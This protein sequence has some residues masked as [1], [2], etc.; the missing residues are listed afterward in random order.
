MLSQLTIAKKDKNKP[1][2]LDREQLYELGLQHIKKLSSQIWTDYNIHDP[3]ITTLELLCYALTDLSQRATYPIADL[4]ASE[5]DN[6]QNMQ[7]QFFTARQ[8]LPSRPLTIL[9]YRKLLIDIDGV[10]NAWIEPATTVTYF[11]DMVNGQLLREN[12]NLLTTRQIPITE[13]QVSGLYTVKLEYENH[14]IE[15]DN[16][17]NL[18]EA[19]R[20]VDIIAKQKLLA[21]RNICED[22]EILDSIQ[23]QLFQLCA[24]LELTPDAD[25]AKVNQEVYR[26]IQEYLAPSVKFYTLSEMLAYQK[27]DGTTYTVDEIFDGPALTKGFIPDQELEKASLRKEIRLSDIISIIMDI[28]GVRAIRDIVIHHVDD[29][30]IAQE[31]GEPLEKQWI[32]QVDNNRQ[33]LLDLKSSHLTFY[34]RNMPILPKPISST[35]KNTRQNPSVNDLEIPVGTHRKLAEYYSFQ[36]HFPIVYGI[37]NVGLNSTADDERQAQAYQLK[38]YLLFFDQI[39]ANYL[40]QLS[41]IKELFSAD[42]NLTPS[43]FYK[44]V[45]SFPNY[46]HIYKN[47]DATNILQQEEQA[48][49]SDRRNRFLDH[50]I[51]RF[52]E[53][54]HDFA[55]TMYAAFGEDPETI[56]QSKCRFLQD[57]P[58]ISS[59][60]SL[61]YNYS[62]VNEDDLW[63]LNNIS[64]LEKRL[65]KLLNIPDRPQRQIGE[66]EGMYLIEHILLRP[67]RANDPFLPIS[68]DPN[69]QDCVEADPYSYRITVL[70][71]A[72]NGRFRNAQFRRFVEEVIREETPAHIYP[73]ICWINN[74]DMATIEE[75]YQEWIYLKARV[76]DGDRS[77]ILTNFIE[78]LFK[79]RSIYPPGRLRDLSTEE[80]Q[81]KFILGQT[82]LGTESESED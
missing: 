1:L 16:E 82:I 77:A 25:T 40:A 61:A 10:K 70:L 60:R 36:N 58:T 4:L 39:M 8:I 78:Q 35:I 71:P 46:D 62:L 19:K 45:D 2:A 26:Q 73:K 24:E 5:T 52:A 75:R 3:G 72:T 14:I 43:Y 81:D 38:A 37:S 54:F 30:I 56:I 18:I 68:P 6:A 34:K 53:Q 41:H 12:P 59:E 79:V 63:N 11:A 80:S 69:C 33:A 29:V 28:T 66:Q 27:A 48:M 31:S 55:N 23:A 32:L 42:E 44:L 9:D 47:A 22:F 64:G 65:A 7:Q 13:V 15:I 50:L 17:S 74:E 21:N 49:G 20:A 67:S 76:R 57:Y 51:S